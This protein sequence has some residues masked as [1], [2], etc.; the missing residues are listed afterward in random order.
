[1]EEGRG[2]RKGAAKGTREEGFRKATSRGKRADR[3]EG[4][5]DATWASMGCFI[6]GFPDTA[7]LS[8][9]RP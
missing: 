6:E 3:K 4:G 2:Q 7:S 1:M 5:E 9:P 8:T